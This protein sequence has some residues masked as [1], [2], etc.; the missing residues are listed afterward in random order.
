VTRP[1]VLLVGHGSK[2]MAGNLDFLKMAERAKPRF[3]GRLLKACFIEYCDPEVPEGLDR[4]VAEGAKDITVV[5][6]ILF[7]AGHVKM[8]VPGSLDQARLRHPGVAFRYGSHIGIQSGLFPVL[9]REALKVEAARGWDADRAKTAVLLIGRG[10][11][12]PD[13]NGDLHKIA[14]LLWEGRGYRDVQVC[15]SGITHP[16]FPEGLRRTVALGATRIILLPYFLF[17]G[18]LL[19]RLQRQ[20]EEFRSLYPGVDW[21]FGGE[22]GH[23][24]TLLDVVKARVEEAEAGEVRMSC[25]LC[26]HRQHA[27]QQAHA[28]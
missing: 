17:T 21:G 22:L 13:A 25:D 1:A 26:V 14:R 5:P 23:E 9:E 11:S 3:P 19:K 24:E 28:H 15:F 8:D 2:D 12:D 16:R 27:A 18:I 4:L 6:V 7:A 20:A 10:S